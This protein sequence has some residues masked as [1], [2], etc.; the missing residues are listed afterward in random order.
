[1]IFRVRALAGLETVLAERFT[2]LWDA[3]A[4]AINDTVVQIDA[5]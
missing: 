2:G 4:A 1:V 3:E 5:A